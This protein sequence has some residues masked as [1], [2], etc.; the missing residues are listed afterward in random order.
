MNYEIREAT[1][2]DAVA[3]R[4]MHA[5]SWLATYPNDEYGIT[6]EW[7]K[8]YTDQWFT[9]ESVEKSRRIVEDILTDPNH[10]Y[11]IATDGDQVVGMV[12][13]Q[14]NED[15]TKELEAIYTSPETFG[16]G[17]GQQLMDQ[18]IEWT[19]GAA[20]TLTVVTYNAR[21]IRFYEKNGFEIIPGS[22]DTYKEKFPVIRMIRKGEDN[23]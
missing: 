6:Y 3:A 9:P 17:L 15:G 7:V 2:D 23:D 20:T 22:E 10:F 18:A 5:E 12:N 1:V 14:G 21:A 8:E 19:G 13:M 4:R 16:T 11:R